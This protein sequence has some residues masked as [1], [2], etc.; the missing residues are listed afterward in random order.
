MEL[1]IIQVAINK[2]GSDRVAEIVMDSVNRTIAETKR[3]MRESEPRYV[4]TLKDPI[5]GRLVWS[6]RAVL[7]K[8]VK[9]TGARTPLYQKSEIDAMRKNMPAFD[10]YFSV[11][12]AYHV[13]K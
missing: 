2:Y 8:V 10:T 4:V 13:Q 5:E 6:G 12:R 3:Q 7:E 1:G 11:R 9:G